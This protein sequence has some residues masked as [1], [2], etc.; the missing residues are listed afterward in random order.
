MDKPRNGLLLAAI[1]AVGVVDR[2]TQS[3]P[4]ADVKPWVDPVDDVTSPEFL[5]DTGH[6]GEWQD[7]PGEE[8][9]KVEEPYGFLK[10]NY[11]DAKA[12][13]DEFMR[14]HGDKP[15]SERDLFGWFANAI[16]TQHFDK[17]TDPRQPGDAVQ[18][19]L[20]ERQNT[21]GDFDRNSEWGQIVKE[22]IRLTPMY[23]RLKPWQ[24][25]ALEYLVNKMTRILHGNP[26]EPDHWKDIAGYAML[27]FNLLTK[28]RNT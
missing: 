11:R 9:A 23:H 28:G 16:E 13:T 20:A 27:P 21:H 10:G 2:K 6:E 25:E 4:V 18:E 8:S 12:W 17:A 7:L 15:L 22:L 24:R 1:K 26:D 19:V 14:L 5:R 3:D